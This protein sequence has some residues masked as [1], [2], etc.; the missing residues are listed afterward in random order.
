MRC[1]SASNCAFVVLQLLTNAMKFRQ[2]CVQSQ[3]SPMCISTRQDVLYRSRMRCHIANATV[4]V[5]HLPHRGSAR[6]IRSLRKKRC[7]GGVIGNWT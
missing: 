5:H 3:Y 6:S 1:L 7:V 2:L 4:L